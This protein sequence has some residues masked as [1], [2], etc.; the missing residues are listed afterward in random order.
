MHMLGLGGRY[1]YKPVNKKQILQKLDIH[2][3]KIFECV[4]FSKIIKFS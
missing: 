4:I 3:E 1:V 2:I